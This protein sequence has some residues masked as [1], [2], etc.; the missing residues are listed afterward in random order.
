V[1]VF[2]RVAAGQAVSIVGS[3]VALFALGLW[4]LQRTGSSTLYGLVTVAA[5]GPGTVF[6]PVAGR[7]VDRA[8][9]RRALLVAS[10]GGALSA[11][12]L[13]GALACGASP[14]WLLAIAACASVFTALEHPAL[15]VLVRTAVPEASWSRANGALQLVFAVVAVATPLLGATA[16]A[17][18]G[19]R[20]VVAIDAASFGAALLAALLTP[21]GR[22]VSRDAAAPASEALRFVLARRD[23]V[24]NVVVVAL[25]ALAFGA[26]QVLATP[27]LLALADAGVAAR[28]L[29]LAALGAVA[30]GL[31]VTAWR[32]SQRPER[33]VLAG[34]LG[35]GGLL[36]AAGLARPS[37]ALVSVVTCAVTA[38]VPLLG[39]AS[40]TM[41]QRAVP[42]E[43][44]GRASSLRTAVVRA[45]L[46][47]GALAAG[48][49]LERL[50][51]P[52]VRARAGASAWAAAPGR[53]AA[54]V[55][56]GLGVVLVVAGATATLL[57][58][59][60]GAAAAPRGAATPARHLVGEAL[61][62]YILGLPKELG[63]LR[64]HLTRNVPATFSTRRHLAVMCGA[65]LVPAAVAIALVRAPTRLDLAI[66][67]ATIV[68]ANLVEYLAHRWLF[69]R[70]TWPHVFY[71]GHV[72][73]HLYF[74]RGEVR[75]REAREHALVLMPFVALAG[76][77]AVAGPAAIALAAV[78]S[79]NAA[80]LF[81]AVAFAY[82]VAY[83]L[84]HLAF[85]AGEGTWAARQP[86]L[87]ALA[88]R[89]HRHHADR[90]A[91]ARD[92]NVFLP[93]WDRA[94]GTA[95]KGETSG[96]GGRVVAERG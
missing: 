24:T 34:V 60:P 27:L 59:G 39:T 91:R 95:T 51:S 40:Q 80:A 23:L 75:V 73:H 94:F 69:H 92:Y 64:A 90:T 58:R 93:I 29:S 56:A 43:L 3:Q 41:W 63:P 57:R 53:D 65:A 2:A 12:A 52:L 37:V 87:R 84:V 66:V 61:E 18:I 81:V 5:L 89:H 20:G 96:A 88:R 76:M 68:F 9:P 62:Q 17:A 82:Y 26:L 4:L 32:G 19:L 67:P 25:F 72:A 83:E 79:R 30:S 46:P 1:K 38:L 78:A 11:C 48:P 31:A 71:Q 6:L 42:P 22:A 44:L 70:D 8:G 36:L 74:P 15:A 7:V 35:A 16:L 50:V 86:I 49:A 28:V 77:A 21:R 47:L 13:W 85:H 14:P 33:V 45:A 54:I 55:V 10:V